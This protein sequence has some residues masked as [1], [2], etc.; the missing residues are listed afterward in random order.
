VN[1]ATADGTATAPADYTAISSTP[2]TFNPGE[3]TKPITVVV[4]SDSFL[5]PN[6]TFFVN[7]SGA[8]N[9]TIADAQ[10]LGTIA[11]NN[12]QPPR[13]SL[14][15]TPPN[16]AL[17]WPTNSAGFTLERAGLLRSTNTQW[18]MVTNAV[19]V[20]VG[21]N[22]VVVSPTTTNNFFRLRKP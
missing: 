19:T 8:V 17:E 2:P 20:V 3:T 16:L 14:R 10:G 1:C 9:A 4:K 13:L 22:Q 18:T 5:E 7:L 11:N 6:E 21:T 15:Q 12:S